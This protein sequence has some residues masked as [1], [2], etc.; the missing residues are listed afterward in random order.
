[1]FFV[2]G[3]GMDD[4]GDG[5][6]DEEVVD[7]Y[8]NDGDGEIDEDGRDYRSVVLVKNTFVTKDDNTTQVNKD[9]KAY[10]LTKSQVDHLNTIEK[11]EVID[12]DMNGQMGT[13]DPKE[14]EYVIRDPDD[15][16]EQ[17]NH[18]LKF[19]VDLKFPGKNLADKIKNKELIRHDTDIN[20]IKYSLKKRKEMVGGCWVNYSDDD[21]KK[22]FEG[23]NAK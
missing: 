10:D 19:A 20:N 9:G 22:W 8:D 13:N 12:I 18:L 6:V 4:D 5:C 15:R 14:W 3:N 16:D 2:F 17:N 1:V 11:Y 23:R 7:N 21:F